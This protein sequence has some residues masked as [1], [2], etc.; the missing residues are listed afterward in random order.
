MQGSNIDVDL[1][2]RTA[3][4]RVLVACVMQDADVRSWLLTLF[5]RSV[6]LRPLVDVRDL[7]VQCIIL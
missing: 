7:S 3:V 5:P 1:V 4:L 6:V 2:P